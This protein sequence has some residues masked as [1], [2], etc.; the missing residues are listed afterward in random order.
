MKLLILGKKKT[1]ECSRI[2][3][4]S[5]IAK[6]DAEFH[7]LEELIFY[8]DKQLAIYLS[9]KNILDFEVILFRGVGVHLNTM[10]TLASYLHEKGKIVIDQKLATT[11][12]TADKTLTMFLCNKYSLPYAKT[13]Q[14]FSKDGLNLVRDDLSF[15]LI[16]KEMVSSQGKGVHLVKNMRDMTDLIR[17]Q[18]VI[19]T[20]LLQ[21]K[22]RAKAEDYR[23]LVVGGKGLGVMKKIA[24]DGEYRSN[25][26][27]GGK[28]EM[29][30]NKEILK[31]GIRA[32][33]V[34]KTEIAGVDIMLDENNNPY[35]LEINRAPQ[36]QRFEKISRI[37][38]AEE[39]VNHCISK[40]QQLQK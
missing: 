8:H 15:S 29:I 31:L 32:A 28:T 30:K 35:I 6:V 7:S 21:E 12:Y 19:G 23:V 26:S 38:V 5:T 39:I 18:G 40:Y 22:L 17:K 4:E 16:V 3:E 10:T 1:Y 36:F 2:L 37:N 34:T 14:I 9:D 11:K 24:R 33:Q 27:Q 25:V 20:L 13:L